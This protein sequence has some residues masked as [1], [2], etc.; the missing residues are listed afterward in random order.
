MVFPR[1]MAMSAQ[2]LV[3]FWEGV[4]DQGDRFELIPHELIPGFLSEL[5]IDPNE[6]WPQEVRRRDEPNSW[7][8]SGYGPVQLPSGLVLTDYDT[9]LTA[10]VVLGYDRDDLSHWFIDLWAPCEGECGAGQGRLNDH[11]HDFELNRHRVGH[12]YVDHQEL[13]GMFKGAYGTGPREG[14]ADG[15]GW[16]FPGWVEPERRAHFG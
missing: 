2:G 9:L 15:I 14:M 12:Q 16:M 10:E 8:P 11:E 4:A 5:G 6:F 1:H 7:A 3:V 13:V